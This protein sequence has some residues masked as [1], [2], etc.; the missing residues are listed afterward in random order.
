MV[1]NTRWIE[2][3][4]TRNESLIKLI[5]HTNNNKQLL[6]YFSL[7]N[8][9]LLIVMVSLS[10]LSS[11]W[12]LSLMLHHIIHIH[13]FSTTLQTTKEKDHLYILQWLIKST[14]EKESLQI[15]TLLFAFFILGS[16]AYCGD[17]S[18]VP[19]LILEKA[20][21]YTLV[22]LSLCFCRYNIHKRHYSYS[23]KPFQH[24]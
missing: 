3:W 12:L 14:T 21:K 11:S 17:V 19:F 9:F 22:T 2:K 1:Q 13:H 8:H 16:I 24:L 7:V 20:I 10:L 4:Q 15:H 6:L 5:N 23:T 18:F